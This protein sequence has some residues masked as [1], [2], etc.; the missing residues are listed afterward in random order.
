MKN[1]CAQVG[2]QAVIEGVMMRSP[3]C[4]A[5][6]VRRLSGEIVLRE[7]VWRSLWSKLKFLRLPFFRGAIVMI[8][9]MVNGMQALSFSAREAMTEEEKAAGKDAQEDSGWGMVLTIALG[10]VIAIGLFKVLPHLAATYTGQLLLGRALTVDDVAYHVVDGVVKVGIFIGYVA[11]IGLSKDIRRV[12]MYHGAEHMAIYTLEAQEPLTVENARRKSTLHPR[13]GT[14][15]LMVVIL[16]FIIIAAVAM[17]FIPQ[18]AKPSPEASWVRHLYVV[19]FKLPLLLPVAG[20]AYEFNRFAG[21]H[22]DNPFLKFLL[23]PGLGMQLLTTKRPDDDQVE[24][25][26]VALRTTLWREQVGETGPT[27]DTP[28][29]FKD[30][31]AFERDFPAPEAGYATP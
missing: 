24:I 2:G 14:A 23:W 19:M 18:W 3:G 20:I 11:V 13:C 17:P 27:H 6:A 28:V 30:F 15:F 29:V 31:T 16:L 4:L 12:F 1:K 7:D 26:L 9:A 8:E 25:A 10:L 21:R 5:V 22:A